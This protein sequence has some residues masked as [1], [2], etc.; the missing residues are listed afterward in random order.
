MRLHGSSVTAC[1]QAGRRLDASKKALGLAGG[2]ASAKAR[3][4]VL[5][6]T[7][8]A[9]VGLDLGT[10]AARRAGEAGPPA[11]ELQVMLSHPQLAEVITATGSGSSL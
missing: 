9:V 8:A 7:W 6:R 2:V 4:E 1:Q 5:A 10:R 11:V 3:I